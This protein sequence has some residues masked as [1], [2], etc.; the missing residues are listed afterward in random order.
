MSNVNS[1]WEIMCKCNVPGWWR[2]MYKN[3]V[4]DSSILRWNTFTANS[5]GRLLTTRSVPLYEITFLYSNG[6]WPEALWMSQFNEKKWSDETH[7]MKCMRLNN[8][9]YLN[10]KSEI[11]N[12]NMIWWKVCTETTRNNRLKFRQRLIR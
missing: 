9:Q 8:N 10:H 1:I 12:L 6:N 2:R 4:N 3:A 5:H 7:I 11:K